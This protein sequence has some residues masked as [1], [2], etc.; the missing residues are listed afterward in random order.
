MKPAWSL[1]NVLAHLFSAVGAA[2]VSIGAPIVLGSGERGILALLLNGSYLIVT[3]AFLGTER[4]IIA[5]GTSL[6][7]KTLWRLFFESLLIV[8]VSSVLLLGTLDALGTPISMDSFG[9]LVVGFV[10]SSVAVGFLQLVSLA[11]KN[12]TFLCPRC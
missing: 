9:T 5:L 4:P 11:Q 7:R 2:V 6:N 8:A 3:L 12:I 10:V 1:L